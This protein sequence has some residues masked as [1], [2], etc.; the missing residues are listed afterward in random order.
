MQTSNHAAA[1]KHNN[2]ICKITKVFDPAELT[3]CIPGLFN[4]L[5]FISFDLVQ[6]NCKLSRKTKDILKLLEQIFCD[7]IK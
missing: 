5:N 6:N 4:M 7:Q 1:T 3:H 2:G